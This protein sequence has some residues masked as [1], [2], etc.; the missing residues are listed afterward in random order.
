MN[1]ALYS[2]KIESKTIDPIR[3]VVQAL[4]RRGASLHF[5]QHFEGIFPNEPS[6]FSQEL[7]SS[8]QLLLSLGGDGTVLETAILV[9]NSG[10]PVL[11]LNFGKMG[12]LAAQNDSFEEIAQALI[13]GNY[14]LESRTLLELVT[15]NGLFQQHPFALN[16]LT[17][18][19]KDRAS[20]IGVHVT[21]NE[22]RLS[23]IWADGII[24]A[25]PTGSTGY[26]LSCGGPIAFPESPIFIVSP[27]APHQLNVRP[28]VVPDHAVIELSFKEKNIQFAATLDSRTE[29]FDSNITLQVK[30]ANFQFRLVRLPWENFP[31]NIRKKLQWGIDVRN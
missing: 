28:V 18:L 17:I 16:D 5:H 23:T 25:T 9:K 4:Q 31:E 26:S 3:N 2:R 15:P 6:Y 22:Q 8:I 29:W 20:M 10:I 30:K 24:V 7:P 21:V 19:K 14:Q 27:I 1:I 11:G 13:T 12:F